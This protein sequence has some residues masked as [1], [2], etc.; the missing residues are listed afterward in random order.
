MRAAP[1]LLTWS[2]IF[3]ELTPLQLR[4]TVALMEHMGLIHSGGPCTLSSGRTTSQPRD[5]ELRRFSLSST[6]FLDIGN[7]NGMEQTHW[8]MIL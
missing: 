7:R 1:N 4:F 6:D 3:V 2:P 5:A 8:E